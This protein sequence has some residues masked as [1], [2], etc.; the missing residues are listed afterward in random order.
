MKIQG[1][2]WPFVLFTGWL[3]LVGWIV[4]EAKASEWWLIL[5]FFGPIIIAVAI[6]SWNED[7]NR[8]D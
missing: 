3:C 1:S 7:K 5:A 6:Q 2:F 4:K 8:K